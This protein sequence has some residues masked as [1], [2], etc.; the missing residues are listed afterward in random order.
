MS[1]V[2]VFGTFDG[3][4]EGHRAMLAEAAKHGQVVVCLA[5]DS[6]VERLKA[7]LPEQAYE[8]RHQALLKSGLITEVIMGDDQDGSYKCLEQ[9]QPDKIAF[10]YD[11]DA[12]RQNFLHWQQLARDDRPHLVLQPYR[13]EIYKSSLLR[14]GL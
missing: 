2:L 7:R 14:Q 1:R 6:V 12:L 11:Q 9:A 13:P 4:H 10:G 5:P 8:L 3:L